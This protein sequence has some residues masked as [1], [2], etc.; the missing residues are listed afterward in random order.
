MVGDFRKALNF[1]EEF[2]LVRA[3]GEGRGEVG[4]LL[5]DARKLPT[6]NRAQELL[7]EITR[8]F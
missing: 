8:D 6:I 1:M 7:L 2:V 5:E 4:G 3:T